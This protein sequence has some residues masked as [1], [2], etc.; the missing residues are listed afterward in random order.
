MSVALEVA[1]RV[2]ASAD[3]CLLRKNGVPFQPEL[4]AGAVVDGGGAETIYNHFVMRVAGLTRETVDHLAECRLAEI[5]RR[6]TR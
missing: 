1:R 2:R 4:A 3:L 5:E 6:R